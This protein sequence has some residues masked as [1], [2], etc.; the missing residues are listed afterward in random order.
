MI[1]R[2][3]RIP[4]GEL[5]GAGAAVGRR[6]AA[7]LTGAAALPLEVATPP[8]TVSAISA[9]SSTKSGVKGLG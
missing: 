5:V 1:L 9:D 4:D 8:P 2:G 6:G 7:E 3:P